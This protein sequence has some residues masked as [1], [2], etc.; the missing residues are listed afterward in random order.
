MQRSLVVGLFT[1]VVMIGPILFAS[2]ASAG[3]IWLTGHDADFH[4]AGNQQCNHFGIALDF[5]RQAAPDKTKPI[6]FLDSGT[7][8]TTA[9]GKVPAKAKNTVEGAGN[10]FNFTV[11]DPTSAG[12]ASL[13]LTTS[14][15]S[16]IVVASDSSCG[17]CDNN[18]ADIAAINA[19]TADLTLF[20]NSGGGLA[21]F[22]GAENRG[23]YYQS[24]PIPATGV[25]V[26]APFTLT[27]DGIAIGLIGGSGSTSD[28]N[29]C[30]THN[31]FLLPAAG[32]PLKVA[33][34]DSAGFAETLFAGN[35]SIGP[36]G[37]GGGGGFIP[38]PGT[39]GD[40]SVPEPATVLLL[41][42]GLF[43]LAGFRR[44]FRSN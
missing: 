16:A 9:A 23:T 5:V 21:Y 35:V 36:P 38:T 4:C 43:A 7:E 24:V 42:S 15:F 44:K 14:A 30:P 11:V 37:D 3:N 22:A 34:T 40:G 12:F 10:P 6:L 17:G 31:S 8:L 19:R 29:C 41:G 28:T 13:A 18:A 39:P 32:S 26:S 1:L 25:A 33:E 2:P 20:F 27:A